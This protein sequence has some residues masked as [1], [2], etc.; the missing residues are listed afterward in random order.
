METDSLS[1]QR[2][3]LAELAEYLEGAMSRLVEGV[4]ALAQGPPLEVPGE[5]PV[6]VASDS[7][8]G[9]AA[10]ARESRRG[11]SPV[12]PNDWRPQR[13]E[14]WEGP[15]PPDRDIALA[16]EL[17]QA[18]RRSAEAVES[19]LRDGIVLKDAPPAVYGL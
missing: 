13:Q 2:D 8:A 17:L 14:A 11:Q 9:E 18:G 10:P 3:R 19:I 15:S 12:D 16:E 6:A 7:A 1:L 5:T 4:T